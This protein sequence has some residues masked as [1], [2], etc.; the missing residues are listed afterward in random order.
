MSESSLLL[1]IGV[2]LIVAFTAA[3]L[4][5]R[6]GQ[7]V[8][9]GYILAG[10]LIGPYM[11]FEV[12]GFQYTGLI[13]DPSLM[14][15]VSEIGIVLLM[16]FV[17]L[18][19]SVTKLRKVER[20]A[21]VLSIINIGVNIFGG[22]L[23]GTALGWPLLDTIFLASI[24]SMSCAAVAMKSLMELGRLT[25]PETEFILGVMIVEDFISAIFLAVISGLMV[26]AS[27]ASLTTFAV[28]AAAFIIFFAVLAILV[29]PRTVRLLDRMKNDEMF[30]ILALGL[31]CLSAAVAEYCAIP[32]MIGA[33][34]VGMSFAETTITERMQEKLAPFRDVFVAVFFLAFGTLIDPTLFPAVIGIVAA[35]VVMV[36]FNDVFITAMLSYFIGYG[37]RQ[38]T[39]VS[40]SMCARGAESILYASVGKQAATVV[41]GAEMY[42]LA[43]AFT[44]ILSVLCPWLMRRSDRIADALTARMPRF[45]RYSAAVVSRTLG[46]LMVADN[47]LR[48]HGSKALMA[49]EIAYLASLLALIAATGPGRYAL[50]VITVASASA[51]WFVLQAV[52]RPAVGPIDFEDLGMIADR[53]VHLSRFVATIVLVTLLTA[54]CV[55]LLFPIFWPTVLVILVAF[56]MWFVLV[57]KVFH[58]RTR[59]GSRYAR[60]AHGGS[61]GSGPSLSAVEGPDATLDHH[62]RWKGL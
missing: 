4:A 39:A 35:A 58:D 43:G 59:V 10:I 54:A 53:D 12:G 1:D 15:L 7:S 2:I 48:V 6:F 16:F 41:K 25:A 37:P 40:T 21:I 23:L 62:R 8:M 18:E 11:V 9:L 26:E 52:L 55:T 44:F 45:I 14:S 61:I 38:S 17:G 60:R 29:I 33:F 28:G 46:R 5:N 27:D 34:F 56:T 22:I 49:T 42:P 51:M 47:E 24:L 3:A 36:L 57:L 13:A 20:P 50:F 32:G 31:V 30:V 19:F